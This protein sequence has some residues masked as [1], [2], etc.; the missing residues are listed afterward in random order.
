MSRDLIGSNKSWAN[1]SQVSMS[2]VSNDHSHCSLLAVSPRLPLYLI[3]R[4]D[5]SCDPCPVCP[6]SPTTGEQNNRMHSVT[7]PPAVGLAIRFH[8]SVRPHRQCN[9]ACSHSSSVPRYIRTRPWPSV[10]PSSIDCLKLFPFY[11]QRR[12]KKVRFMLP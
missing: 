9:R 2:V 6:L 11:L 10:H 5:L 1:C 3:V 4:P 12:R 8:S 7:R